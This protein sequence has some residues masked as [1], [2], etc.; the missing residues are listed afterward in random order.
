VMEYLEGETLEAQIAREGPLPTLRA[1]PI[2]RQVAGAL[3]AAHDLKIVHRDVK[4]ENIMLTR[5][6]G[7]ASEKAKAGPLDYVKMLD[8]GIAKVLEA[9]SSTL[10]PSGST[11]AGVVFGSPS[12]MSPEAALGHQVDHRSDIYQLGVVLFDMVTGQRPF[13][14]ASSVEIMTKQI[15]APVPSPR[16]LVPGAHIPESVEELILK[17]MAKQPERRQQSMD[18]M[19]AEIDSILTAL[20][21]PPPSLKDDRKASL[22]KTR[23]GRPSGLTEEFSAFVRDSQRRAVEKPADPDWDALVA[24]DDDK[25][26]K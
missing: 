6:P 26:K 14:G 9:E 25:P 19:I 13:N 20:R 22:K 3:A 16:A 4:P 24:R 8:F 1:L 15:A 23:A 2:A 10:P 17:A 11:A 5:Q 21:P 18:E 7:R 12:Y